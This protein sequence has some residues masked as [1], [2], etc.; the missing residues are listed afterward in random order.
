MK[1]NQFL[2][3]HGC[4]VEQRPTPQRVRDRSEELPFGQ[5]R[6]IREVVDAVRHQTKQECVL[7]RPPRPDDEVVQ[8]ENQQHVGHNRTEHVNHHG[9][10]LHRRNLASKVTLDHAQIRK[11]NGH[12]SQRRDQHLVLL[13]L[14][15][16]N[17]MLMLLCN[18]RTQKNKNI[19][20]KCI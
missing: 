3:K 20:Q 13:L 6:Q 18:M 15:Q 17:Q 4:Q 1:S 11:V 8:P 2:N 7:G 12:E 5:Q 19:I 10:P 14:H 16:I 9:R